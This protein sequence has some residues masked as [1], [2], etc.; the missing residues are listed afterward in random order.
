MA[1][2]V[3]ISIILVLMTL[4]L[5]QAS[6]TILVRVLLVGARDSH[7]RL[8]LLMLGIFAVHLVE[9]LLYAAGFYVAA[10]VFD[11]GLLQGER[12]TGILGHFYASAVFYTSLGL[13][14]VLPNDH[15]RFL[16]GVEA[17]NG[18][19]LIAWSASFLFTAMGQFWHCL[20]GVNAN[21]PPALVKNRAREEKGS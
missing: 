16:A 11:L 17:L 12:A 9:I 6:F 19:L 3:L 7:P 2:T 15:L 5:H 13:G 4:C 10:N 20:T 21:G 8:Y 18:L 14:D 1:T